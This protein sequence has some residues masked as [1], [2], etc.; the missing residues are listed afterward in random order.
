MFIYEKDGKLNISFEKKTIPEEIT[1]DIVMSKEGSTVTVSVG[2]YDISGD[3]PSGDEIVI[4]MEWDT[5]QYGVAVSTE[6]SYQDVIDA[7]NAGMTVKLTLDELE[8]EIT[9]ITYYEGSESYTIQTSLGI[10][11]EGVGAVDLGDD[12]E[13][14]ALMNCGL[15]YSETENAWV[16]VDGINYAN[17]VAS[18]DLQK[19]IAGSASVVLSF[20]LNEGTE[21]ATVTDYA[22]SEGTY[23]FTATLSG[24]L[25]GGPHSTTDLTKAI[26]LSA[27]SPI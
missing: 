2:D 18:I 10:L 24:G 5:Q 7:Y 6:Y 15:V 22:V 13:V 16:S 23:T 11:S 25:V 17:L 9:S 20:N 4:P 3:T 19:Q 14:Y 26:E 1:P 21:T 27:S 12:F 8:A